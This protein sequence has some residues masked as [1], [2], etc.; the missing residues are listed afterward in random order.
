MQKIDI[1]EIIQK[2]AKSDEW[3][4]YEAILNIE[5]NVYWTNF[6]VDFMSSKKWIV[7][8]LELELIKNHKKENEIGKTDF[9][10][11]S[12]RDINFK[13]FKKL[14]L[15][16]VELFI[17]KVKFCPYCWK[18]PLI[19]YENDKKEKKWTFHLD[20][21]FP[22]SKYRY[23]TYNFYNLIPS[24]SICNQLKWAK[25]IYVSGNKI[26]HPYL[27]W[28]YREW[29][30]VLLK[31]ATFDEE[32]SLTSNTKDIV[33]N[34]PHFKFFSL[35]KI[36]PNAQDTENDIL[37]IRESKEK[38][39]ATKRLFIKWKSDQDFKNFFFKNY[40]PSREEEILKFSNGK[41]KKD[42]IKNLNL[43]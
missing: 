3:K 38:I 20:H 28:V 39:L 31:D 6:S 32:V 29:N 37:F 36:Y 33:Y 35:N 25:N 41:L 17:E 9:W 5:K 11:W 40:A 2:V 8:K 14:E 13:D 15:K 43:D 21:I 34:S 42:M 27:W 10:K 16:F 7:K 18:I 12:N 26:F 1:D 24:C 19:R 22:K 23:L 30:K 4:N